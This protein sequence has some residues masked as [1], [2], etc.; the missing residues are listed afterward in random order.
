MAGL[1][2]GVEVEAAADAVTATMATL[3]WMSPERIALDDRRS[4]ILV[5]TS[6]GDADEACAYAARRVTKS[7]IAIGL[8]VEILSCE[9]FPKVVDL[10]SR[11][12]GRRL[13][14]HRAG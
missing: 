11:S 10:R 14:D 6:F 13:R 2:V 7:T 4:L 3:P 9:A 1:R 5:S 12:V 8:G